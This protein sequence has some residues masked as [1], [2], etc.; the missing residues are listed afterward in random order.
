MELLYEYGLLAA[1]PVETPFPENTVL[2]FKES[3][4]DKCLLNFTSYEQLV[5][6]LIY[7]TNTRPDI[8][9]AV[10]CLSQHMHNPLQSHFKAALRVL[11]QNVLKQGAEAEYR[12]LASNTYEVIWLGNLLHSLGLKSFYPVDIF[13]D[14]SS[15]IQIAVNPVFHEK[16]KH[17][18]LDVYLVREKV[19]A[20]VIKTIKV[21][22]DMQSAD[23]FT[24]CL[25]TMQHNLFCRSLGMKDMFAVI[26]D[27]KDVKGKR[28]E[29]VVASKSVMTRNLEGGCQ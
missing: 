25:G 23:I 1:R 16:T 9:Y 15:T 20:G 8:S 27:D 3:E 6:K 2:N 13:Y 5:G 4:K 21:H 22:T 14:S 17:F 26:N 24:K 10:H 29:R 19:S 28:N 11:R 12:S 7:F 18:E